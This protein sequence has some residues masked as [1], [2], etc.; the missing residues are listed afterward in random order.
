MQPNGRIV[1]AKRFTKEECIVALGY[2]SAYKDGGTDTETDFIHKKLMPF[3]G[4]DKKVDWNN[5]L[6]KWST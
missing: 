3:Y 4:L 2:L 1:M 6:D 5:F